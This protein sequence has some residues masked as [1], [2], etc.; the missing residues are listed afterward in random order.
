MV[1]PV[2]GYILHPTTWLESP[3]TMTSGF[4]IHHALNVKASWLRQGGSCCTMGPW[5]FHQELRKPMGEA[6]HHL[7]KSMDF[8]YRTVS[9]LET[10]KE[11]IGTA[12][13]PWDFIG[14]HVI[15]SDRPGKQRHAMLWAWKWGLSPYF[16][17][18][19]YDQPSD[20]DDNPRLRNHGF[21]QGGA[22]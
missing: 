10:I 21:L 7:Q 1:I 16:K 11:T 17:S 5:Q 8:P 18:I 22:P 14:F 20:I 12:R 13:R 19:N 2:S 3:W 9:L 15:F 4:I 6:Y